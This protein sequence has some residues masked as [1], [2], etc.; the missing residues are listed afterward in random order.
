[1]DKNLTQEFVK[2]YLELDECDKIKVLQRIYELLLS[3]ND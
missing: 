1:M 3:N 2:K